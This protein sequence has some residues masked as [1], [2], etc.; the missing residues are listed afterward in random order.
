MH[1]VVEVVNSSELVKW[2]PWAYTVSL[3]VPFRHLFRSN[4]IVNFQSS[5]LYSVEHFPVPRWKVFVLAKLHNHF[6]DHWYMC[7]YINKRIELVRDSHSPKIQQYLKRKGASFSLCVARGC[8]GKPLCMEIPE[9]QAFAGIRLAE[10]QL[11]SASVDTKDSDCFH[12]SLTFKSMAR[13]MSLSTDFKSRWRCLMVTLCSF[14]IKQATTSP[15][16]V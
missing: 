6:H 5:P 12:C 10:W 2:A 16:C 11:V 8:G 4:G 15:W 7:Y 3:Q 1:V 9:K 14:R 13:V